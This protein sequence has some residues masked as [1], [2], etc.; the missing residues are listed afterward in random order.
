MQF[1]VTQCESL[2]CL[3]MNMKEVI[4]KLAVHVDININIDAAQTDYTNEKIRTY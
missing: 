2:P 4:S 1:I 3:T